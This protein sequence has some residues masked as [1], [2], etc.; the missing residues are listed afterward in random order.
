M[1]LLKIGRLTPEGVRETLIQDDRLITP[2]AL[3]IDESGWMY[4]PAPQ[5]EAIS[6]NNNG[7]DET[8][9]PWYIYRFRLPE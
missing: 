9:A 6:T 8:R 5:I 1:T 4:I 3:V 2:D 7:K